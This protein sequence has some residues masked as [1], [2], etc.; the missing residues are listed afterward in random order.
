MTAIVPVQL[1]HNHDKDERKLERQQLR[2][3]VKRKATDDMTARPSKLIR[4]ELHTFSDNVLES[5]DLRSIAQSLY[6]ER[7]KVYPVLPK[8]REESAC[9][10]CD[11]MGGAC[12]I[13]EVSAH[14]SCSGCGKVHYCG[15]EHQRQHWPQHRQQCQPFKLVS[16]AVAGS[17]LVSTRQLEAGQVLM[18]DTP[19]VVG[20][21]AES[22]GVCLGC[23]ELIPESDEVLH[24]PGC[25]WPICSLKCATSPNHFPDCRV[26]ARDT[27]HISAPNN[28]EPTRRYEYILILRCL[29]LRDRAPSAW[30]EVMSMSHHSE[31][32]MVTQEEKLDLIQIFLN[33]VLKLD[34]SKDL[35]NQ[36]VG[37][38]AT[39][40]LEIRTAGHNSIRALYPKVRLLNHSC[41]P[42]VH[43]S[44]ATNGR[45][46]VRAA[47]K[48]GAGKVLSISYTST[49]IPVWE[50]QIILS[51]NY[52]FTCE[53]VR[54]SDQTELGIHFS[55]PRCPECTG[56][57]LEPIRWLGNISWSCP[58]CHLEMKDAMVRAQ[59]SDWLVRLQMDDILGGSGGN[60]YKRVV[61]LLHQVEMDFHPTHFIW[62]KVA[63]ASLYRL[64]DDKSLR[65]LKLRRRLWQQLA[66]LYERLEPGHTRRRGYQDP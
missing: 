33:K 18:E 65:A 41:L 7:R 40:A 43:L 26:L 1:E 52:Y 20:P 46:Q 59:V 21:M 37:A 12:G 24:C 13:C 9:S 60:S 25:H 31:Q 3:Q 48:V 51:D 62:M 30:K 35:I 11:I 50:R 4:T 58:T 28:L 57:Y 17:Y 5:S 54:C 36:V 29:L 19:L 55:S 23:H 32:R 2:T 63:Q 61:A 47:V 39:N 45:M 27:N 10:R 14:L 42:N 22:A 49:T 16:S 53:C 8:T 34:Y 64:R 6:R 66:D 38:V 15:K 44:S 56:S